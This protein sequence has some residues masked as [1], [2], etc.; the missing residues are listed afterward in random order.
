MYL[1]RFLLIIMMELVLMVEMFECP[2]CEKVFPVSNGVW[3]FNDWR[4]K[5]FMF[6]KDCYNQRRNKK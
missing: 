1:K 6:C 2:E 5:A 4:V 3:T